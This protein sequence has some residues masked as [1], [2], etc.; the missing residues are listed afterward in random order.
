MFGYLISLGMAASVANNIIS[1]INA[2]LTIATILSFI[3]TLGV[4]AGALVLIKQMIKKK[5]LR[6]LVN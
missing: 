4:G 2:G 1:M 6:T 5:A 3:S